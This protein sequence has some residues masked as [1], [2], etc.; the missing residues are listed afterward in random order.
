M[1]LINFFQ[2][3]LIV[4][5]FLLR[6]PQCCLCKCTIIIWHKPHD[7]HK[8]QNI[9]HALYPEGSS[10]VGT[11]YEQIKYT[12]LAPIP[13]KA[14]RNSIKI[15]NALVKICTTDHNRILHTS[16]QLHCCDVCKISLWSV[17]YAQNNSITN[18]HWISNSIEISLVGRTPDIR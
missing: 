16:R 9:K 6:R 12:L 18:V 5:I 7:T 10:D 15:W 2:S 4:Y 3:S 17:E 13:L 1:K 11:C 14:F 8:P